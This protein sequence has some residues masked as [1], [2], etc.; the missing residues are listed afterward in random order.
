MTIFFP[1]TPADAATDAL[2]AAF[3]ETGASMGPVLVLIALVAAADA[4]D[5]PS[6]PEG[7]AGADVVADGPPPSASRP[8]QRGLRLMITAMPQAV[9]SINIAM[10]ATSFCFAEGP[11][12]R[13]TTVGVLPRRGFIGRS[14]MRTVI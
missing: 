3:G 4:G 11:R 12:G 10:N 2:A 1:A 8:S 5:T 6:G 7:A 13:T 9:T 14:G